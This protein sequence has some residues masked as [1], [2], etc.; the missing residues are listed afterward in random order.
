MKKQAT[1]WE[2]IFANYI[3]DKVLICK[4]YKELLQLDKK[5]NKT[6][7]IQKL[8]RTKQTFSKDIHPHGQQVHEKMLNFNKHQENAN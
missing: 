5:Q 8:E 1:E 4:T 7:R 2:K 3:S 6:Q